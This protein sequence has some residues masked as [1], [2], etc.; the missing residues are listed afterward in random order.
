MLTSGSR[1]PDVSTAHAQPIRQET[2]P[3]Q[4][5]RASARGTSEAGERGVAFDLHKNS[6]VAPFTSSASDGVKS[7]LKN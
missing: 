1:V 4:R 7:S 2:Q 5:E 6:Y 3:S